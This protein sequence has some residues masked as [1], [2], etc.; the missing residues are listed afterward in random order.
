MTVY[1]LY[2]MLVCYLTHL[3]A[4]AFLTLAVWVVLKTSPLERD[5][6]TEAL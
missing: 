6:N 1:I 3:F 4:G 5:V 2:I